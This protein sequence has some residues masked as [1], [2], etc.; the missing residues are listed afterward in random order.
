MPRRKRRNRRVEAYAK[1]VT[2]RQ[3]RRTARRA[4]LR[5]GLKT[6]EVKEVVS[7]RGR[8]SVA[9]AAAPGQPITP[10]TTLLLS[11]AIRK[12]KYNLR[13]KI[14]RIWFVNG[15]SYDY[16]DVPESIIYD[17]DRAPS[18]GRYFYYNIRTSFK[19][20]KVS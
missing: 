14:L 16:F 2:A 17:L 9:E 19:F 1:R 10:Q 11:T 20:N 3:V 5:I 8:V 4:Q 6:L 12:Y 15:G 18:K 13:S 7:P